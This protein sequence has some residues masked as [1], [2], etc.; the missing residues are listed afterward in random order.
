M[1]IGIIRE[2]KNPPDNRV[3]LSPS[4]CA[5]LKKKGIKVIVESS[6]DRC[7]SDE[8]YRKK[9]IEV[10]NDLSDCNVLMGVKEVP[11]DYLV[12]NKTYFFFSHTIK[13][14]AHNRKLLQAILKKNIR[15]IDYEVLTD[16]S[17][18]RLIAFGKFAGMVGAHNALWTYGQ[19][20]KLFSLPRMK[21]L[22][23]YEE[24][25]EIYSAAKFPPVKIV[26]TGKGRVGQG[27]ALVLDDMGI[28]KITPHDFLNKE[29]DFAVYTHL[30]TEDYVETRNNT[31]FE[32]SEYYKFPNRFENT[33]M[34]YAK[35][36]DIF[37][38][39][40]F[41]NKEAP[42][43]FTSKEMRS[44]DFNIKVI[45]D[46]TCDIAPE[47]SVPSTLFAS[48]I[49]DPVFGYDPK[50]EQADGPFKNDVI[51]VMSIDNLPNELARDASEQFGKTFEALILDA[52]LEGPNHRMMV[53]A[54]LTSNGKLTE[55]F[56]YLEDYVSK[57]EELIS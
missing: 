5:S 34:K 51:D 49:S 26:L 9:G 7:F 17:G 16:T 53:D 29:F 27:A 57:K 43:F 35:V 23:G 19:R 24:A 54:T 30:G 44:T 31:P 28:K 46:V 48:T 36:S 21:D 20:T 55:K 33:F 12:A 47:S 39:G 25:K 52:L 13:E 2:Q 40:I 3:P 41:Y 15:L 14:Q 4:V 42:P 11:I 18:K 45:A 1:T 6:P 56:Q 32:K 10:S 38:N 22:S 50:T 8:E 37:I